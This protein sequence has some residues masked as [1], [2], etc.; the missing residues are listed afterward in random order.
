MDEKARARERRLLLDLVHVGGDTNKTLDRAEGLLR[1]VSMPAREAV[2]C[3][4]CPGQRKPSRQYPTKTYGDPKNA[5]C[6]C[7][8]VHV[9]LMCMCMCRVQMHVHAHVHGHGHGHGPMHA[10]VH[11]HVYVY[12]CVCMSIYRER[13]TNAYIH[14]YICIYMCVCMCVYVYI[15]ILLIHLNSVFICVYSMK[16]FCDAHG[17]PAQAEALQI[18]LRYPEASQLRPGA[19]HASVR[20]VHHEDAVK[21][22][23]LAPG[24]QEPARLRTA[25]KIEGTTARQ[26]HTAGKPTAAEQPFQLARGLANSDGVM[27]RRG[28]QELGDEATEAVL[29]KPIL[30]SPIWQSIKAPKLQSC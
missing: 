2:E 1:T 8:H 24:L 21:Q 6:A 18:Q 12:V 27:R 20:D 25:A 14:I 4:A 19:L 30:G 26:L 11:V 23:Y 29:L 22:A 17:Q 9:M 10:H 16:D 15:Y 13:D 5:A 28:P 7:V 3:R